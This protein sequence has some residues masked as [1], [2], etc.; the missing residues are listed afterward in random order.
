MHCCLADCGLKRLPVSGLLRGD[1][2]GFVHKLDT[3]CARAIEH[4]ES[5]LLR[6]VLQLSFG[7][8]SEKF[9]LGLGWSVNRRRISRLGP[10]C[11]KQVSPGAADSRH[12]EQILSPSSPLQDVLLSRQIVSYGATSR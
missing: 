9:P 6:S 11:S 7:M 3:S 10:E 8:E 5:A 2:S 12:N 4:G 1:R